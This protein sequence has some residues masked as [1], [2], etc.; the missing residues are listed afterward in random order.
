[1]DSTVVGPCTRDN[2]W[3]P[4]VVAMLITFFAGLLILV[5]S[6]LIWYKMHGHQQN[7]KH[8]KFPACSRLRAKAQRL[9]SGNGIPSKIIVIGTFLINLAAVILYLI[10]ASMY[11]NG[12]VAC[13][14]VLGEV[15]PTLWIAFSVYFL[16]VFILRFIAAVDKLYMWV[17]F[18]S[19]VDHFTII[20]TM[21]S[22]YLDRNWFAFRCLRVLH[23]IQT[24]EI[25]Q[26]VG[27]LKHR[28]SI[29]IVQVVSFFMAVWLS[30][31]GF[32]HV[33]ENSGDPFYN[34]S[35]GQ[36]LPYWKG[37]YWLLVTMSTVGYGDVNPATDITKAFII[38]FIMGSFAMFS[39]MIPELIQHLNRPKYRKS[40]RS[41][42][43][44]K[45]IVVCGQI[46]YE[47]VKHLLLNLEHEDA[48]TDPMDVVFVS[49]EPPSLELEAFFRRRCS[50]VFFYRG[51]VMDIRTLVAVKLQDADAAIIMTNKMTDDPDEEDSRNVMRAAALKNFNHDIR[52]IIQL[53]MQYNKKH[54]LHIPKWRWKPSDGHQ[55]QVVCLSELKLGIMAQ[56]C[57]APGITTLLSN[58]FT[59]RSFKQSPTKIVDWT[60]HYKRGAGNEI[61]VETFSSA[62]NGMSFKQVAEICFTQ[63][64]VLLVAVDNR[65]HRALTS[66]LKINPGNQVIIRDGAVGFFFAQGPDDAKRVSLYR[67]SG[68]KIRSKLGDEVIVEDPDRFPAYFDSTGGG[69]I[70]EYG[71]TNKGNEVDGED[72]EIYKE[73]FDPTGNVYWCPPQPIDECTIDTDTA[74]QLDFHNHI[75]VQFH[76]S[77]TADIGLASLVMPLRASCINR[78][79]LKDIVL[80]IDPALIQEEE[81]AT[82]HCLPRLFLFKPTSNKRR[83]LKVV[84]VTKCAM[85]LVLDAGYSG[86]TFENHRSVDRMPILSSLAIQTMFGMSLEERIKAV[87]GHS[88]AGDHAPNLTA[89]GEV[90]M[91]TVLEHDENIVFL[92]P[93]D[94]DNDLSLQLFLKVPYASGRVFTTS[95][96][97][98]LL[99]STYLNSQILR[100]VRALITGTEVADYEM[101]LLEGLGITRKNTMND[102]SDARQRSH[103]AQLSLA[104]GPLEKLEHNNVYGSLF[105]SALCH[106]NL[107]CLG[108]YRLFQPESSNNRKRYVITNPPYQFQLQSTDRIYVLKPF[109]EHESTSRQ[110]SNDTLDAEVTI[111]RKTD[112]QDT[113]L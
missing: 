63:L 90:P 64:E 66:Q 82:I 18:I 22:I 52:I 15:K 83:D 106:L 77:I 111:N 26:L 16:L 30:A 36:D 97:D 14:P 84:N 70:K 65:D 86:K 89:S 92:D 43:G 8:R 17:D 112:L 11:Y 31:S 101:V 1:M 99:S 104:Y 47:N 19:I 110:S 96:L 67:N 53:I 34:Y 94:S 29:R 38:V 24:A 87:S 4:P 74:R 25:L 100:L 78:T 33:T 113:P 51:N 50:D 28:S 40:Y 109:R 49:E 32:V 91:A 41:S 9:L 48:L 95:C 12:S 103:F 55:D 39:S 7:K 54:L 72:G 37:F 23:L 21:M 80:I 2:Q 46:T 10:D 88:E 44:K 75:V 73:L 107:L 62:F 61:Y 5:P 71:I 13:G 68:N 102:L 6:R 76:A 60:Q 79:S 57:L 105:V 45:H 85:C 108:V 58:L 3:R 20:P 56:N 27:L 93:D 59:N 81:W 69:P 98:S 42:Y 35:N